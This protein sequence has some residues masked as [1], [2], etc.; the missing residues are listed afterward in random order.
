MTDLTDRIVERL[1]L[2]GGILN[3]DACRRLLEL[4]R[5]N[6]NLRRALEKACENRYHIC[7]QDYCGWE[8]HLNCQTTCATMYETGP[9][10][11]LQYFM[12]D[13]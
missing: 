9:A 11:W 8:R 1:Q 5:D 2:F 10:C 7:P 6:A 3:D 4:E 12:E 13:K